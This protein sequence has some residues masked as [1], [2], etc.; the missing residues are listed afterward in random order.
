MKNSPK[1]SAGFALKPLVVALACVCSQA[2]LAQE[3]TPAAPTLAPVTVTGSD[4]EPNVLRSTLGIPRIE[5]PVQ[6]IPQVVNVVPQEILQQQQA[7][8]L[9]QALRNVPGITVAIGEANGG[10]N[11]DQFRI[12]G[13]ATKNDAYL[14][15]LRDFG[16]YVRD[17][18]NTEQVEVLK[19]PSSENFGMGTNGGAINSQSKLAHL[20][21][22]ASVEGMFGNGPMNRQTL[23]INRQVGET[24]GLRINAMRQNQDIVDRDGVQSDR[25]GAALSLGMGLGTDTTW[26]LNY[27]HQSND[28]TP[29]F[30]QPLIARTATEVRRP[31]A[32]YGVDR[33][34]YYGKDTDRD[35]THANILTSLFKHQFNEDT[36]VSNE[37]R[38]GYYERRFS[39]TTATCDQACAN[40]FFSGGD[41]KI[42]YGSGGGPRYSQ[43]SDGVQNIT[44][45]ATKFDT[46]PLKHDVRLGLDVSHQT[47]HRQA[48]AYMKPDLSGTTTKIPG[49]L[50]HPD[51]SSSNYVIA[52]DPRATNDVRDSKLTDVALFAT[53][54]VRF[55]PQWSVLGS[56]RWDHYEQSAKLSTGST[57]TVS[58]D[59]RTNSNF[60]SPKASLIWEPTPSQTY[61][62]SYGWAS[63]APWAGSITADANPLGVNSTTAASDALRNLSPEK[64]KTLELGGKISL[65][66]DRLGVSGAIFHTE[67]NNTYYDNGTGGLSATGN[68][69][70]YQGVELGLTGQITKYWSAY[71]GYTYLDSEIKDSA[72]AANIGNPVQGAARNA[73]TLWTSYDLSALTSAYF[74]GRFV[75]GGGATYRDRMYIRDDKMAEVPFSLSYDAM[76]A[77]EYKNVRLALN[78]YNLANRLNYDNFFAGENANTARAIPS[79]GRSFV[80]SARVMF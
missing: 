43:R 16:V 9:E 34:N 45:L 48:Y 2:S 29:D 15:G 55:S 53:D 28:R 25:W 64:T 5:G 12:R 14:D 66:D 11:G 80:L 36:S 31:V 50:Q 7:T 35:R 63:T 38:Y 65:L 79:A 75:I 32:T 24:T 33:A 67:K 17:T 60:F 54:R 3:Q 72:T 57:G 27:M 47:D 41:G 8:T 59:V 71:L 52:K 20:Q 51:N 44:T 6:D 26:Y 46:G 40:A 61:Y 73:A 76:I 21:N 1:A 37:T 4:V 74:P 13:A 62:L 39:T 22:Q 23:D 58:G 69:E 19:G 68:K 49:T 77:Y 70:R 10:A 18:F 78:G 56:V 30:G 42:I